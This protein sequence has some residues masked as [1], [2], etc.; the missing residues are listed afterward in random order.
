MNGFNKEKNPLKTMEENRQLQS[1]KDVRDS[2]KDHLYNFLDKSGQGLSD[3]YKS[4]S[5]VYRD[6]VIP[7]ISSK[8]LRDII[9]GG[10]TLVKNI[11]QVFESPHDIVDRVGNVKTG[12][13][14]KII[15]D[16]PEESLGKILFRKIGGTANKGDLEKLSKKIATA[17]NT[18]YGRYVSDDLKQKLLEGYKKEKNQKRLVTSS[19]WGA[20]GVAGGAGLGMEEY[21]RKKI[22]NSD[23]DYAYDRS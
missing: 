14:N 22:M 13:I 23:K 6:N 21:I 20:G 8:K 4:A 17:E 7:Y 5:D 11:H 9:K 15:E 19:K 12:P 18:G 1:I 10:R 3:A 2:L 16:L